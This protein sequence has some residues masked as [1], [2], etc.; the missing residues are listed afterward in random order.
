MNNIDNPWG[1]DSRPFKSIEQLSPAEQAASMKALAWALEQLSN[2]YRQVD[3]RD[4]AHHEREKL[5]QQ[6][7]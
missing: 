6:R 5:R 7:N 4:R 3:E 1:G 2:H